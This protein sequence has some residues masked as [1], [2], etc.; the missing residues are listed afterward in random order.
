MGI[1]L[2]QPLFRRLYRRRVGE[3]LSMERAIDLGL[4]GIIG[5]LL[6]GK[7]DPPIEPPAPPEA[8]AINQAWDRWFQE[9]G[10]R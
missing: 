8:V 3:E 1:F 5:A 6:Q 2:L 10:E 7:P 4:A 9:R